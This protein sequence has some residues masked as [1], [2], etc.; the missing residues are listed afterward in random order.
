MQNK[1]NQLLNTEPLWRYFTINKIMVNNMCVSSQK[2]VC[3]S[4]VV[5]YPALCVY[6]SLLL[7]RKTWNILV[8]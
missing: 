7:I 5:C 2:S 8:L 6:T 1:N 4:F 3:A